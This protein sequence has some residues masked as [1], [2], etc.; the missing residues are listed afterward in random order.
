MV[1]VDV[2]GKRAHFNECHTTLG[3]VGAARLYYRNVWKHHGTPEKYISDRGSQ[4]VSEFTRELWRLIGIAPATSTA[5]HPQTDGQTERV[6]QELEQFVRIFTNYQQD[7]WD[8][9]L[10]AA[11]FAYNNHIH[12]S[13]QQV[14]FMTDSGRLPRMGFEPN[15]L[16]SELEDV[17][18]FRDRIASG[19]SEAKAALV[20]AKDE[21][22]RYYDR[23]RTAA[24]EIKVG[25]RVW[26]DASD[27]KTTRPT[28]K[29]SHRRLGPFKVLKVVGNGA[30]K[31]DLPRRYSR[32]HPVFPVVKLE[33]AQDEPFPGRPGH[34]EP[35]PD[36]VDGEEEWEIGE[37]L[38]A[39]IRYGSLWYFVRW[40]GYDASKDEW[41]KHSNLHASEAVADFYRR[42]PEKPRH[43]AF[44]AFDS[45]PFQSR[46]PDDLMR[47]DAA[48]QR[49]G[50]VRGTPVPPGS[51]RSSDSGSGSGTSGSGTSGRLRTS[52]SGS[53]AIR[54]AQ[55]AQTRWDQACD[56]ARDDCCRRRA[57]LTA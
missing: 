47:R 2:L 15:G 49:G 55:Q 44:A 7:D 21:Y 4:F 10:P 45:I 54:S 50:S 35:P 3:A 57:K 48:F 28:E 52:A 27:I 6:N 8:E 19:V 20:K 37:I 22:K 17:N 31:L 9:L 23:R 26:L 53:A 36:L 34:S 13:T 1:V 5:W 38:D 46:S 51:I 16:R 39:K 43:I 32:L 42:Y 40:K 41:V 56:A 33:L 14:P 12:S 11:E 30:F 18:E 29:F 25:D 24:P